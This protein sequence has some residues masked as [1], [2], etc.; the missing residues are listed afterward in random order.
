MQ[1]NFK[2]MYPAL[3]KILFINTLSMIVL[4]KLKSYFFQKT[5]N[6]FLIFVY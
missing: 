6:D 3:E 4:K 2:V 1:H 5:Q